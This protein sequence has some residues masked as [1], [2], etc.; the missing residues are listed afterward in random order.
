M[1]SRGL[2]SFPLTFFRL[3]LSCLPLSSPPA[4]FEEVIEATALGLAA[5]RRADDSPKRRSACIAR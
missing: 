1:K 4:L 3:P 5:A 2:E